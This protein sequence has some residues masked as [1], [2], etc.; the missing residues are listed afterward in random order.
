MR[1][2]GFYWLRS[3]ERWS[4]GRYHGEDGW[5]II[6]HDGYGFEDSDFEEID[7]RRIER[8]FDLEAKCKRDFEDMTDT[9]LGLKVIQN[10]LLPPD[11]IIIK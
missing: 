6:G 7:E 4:V 10:D 11:I 2:P 9:A 1:Q 8:H 5:T 3:K